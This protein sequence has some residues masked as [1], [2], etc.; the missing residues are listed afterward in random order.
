MEFVPNNTYQ[1][2]GRC[3]AFNI[4]DGITNMATTLADDSVANI[5]LLIDH[6]IQIGRV[7]LFSFECIF[8][9]TRNQLILKSYQDIF[10]CQ[11]GDDVY[12]VLEKFYPYVKVG[13]PSLESKLDEYL[14]N[15]KNPI[16]KAICDDIFARYRHDFLLYPAAVKMHHNYIGGLA[17]H[18]LSICDLA[19]AFT[20]LYT[21]VD[22][23]FVIA[24]ALLHDVCKVI[25][26]KGPIANEYSIKGHLLGHLVMGALEIEN[27]AN[28]LGFAGKEE[29]MILEHMVI[30]HHGQPLYGACKKPETPE[31]LL[32]WL[33]DTIDSKL[34][35]IDES[36][37]KI[38]SG[39]FSEVLGVLDRSRCYKK[40][41]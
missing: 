28:R 17:Y 15:I 41:C 33:L 6:E 37:E 24:G 2:F 3:D 19:K 4:S 38:D 13:I 21:S 26:F 30:S 20:G 12:P 35:V 5:K 34:R 7:Y 29:V 9:G 23:D 1:V 40:N 8:N 22:T 11:L 18:T 10:T 25:E 27:T 16:V 14:S 39:T 32:L 36:F 31:A